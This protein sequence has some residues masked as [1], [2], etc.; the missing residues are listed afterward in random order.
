MLRTLVPIAFAILAG[1]GSSALIS[2][3]RGYFLEGRI[4][5]GD[6]NSVFV[7]SQRADS[8][9]A[10]PRSE[11]ADIDHPGNVAATIGGI[12]GGYGVANSVVA[13]PTCEQAVAYKEACYVGTLLP[14]AV[15]IPMFIYGLVTW[16]R[17]RSAAE[18][19]V[20]ERPFEPAHSAQPA[21][22]LLPTRPSQPETLPLRGPIQAVPPP[23][24]LSVPVEQPR[25]VVSPGAALPARQPGADL[26]AQPPGALGRCPAEQVADMRSHGV[27]EA[28]IAAACVQP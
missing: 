3:K 19:M 12:L 5:G 20:E 14:L 1:C 22:P 9:I 4:S 13:V 26:P 25:R 15:A 16:Q 21:Y 11:I 24:P 17:S 27:S 10:I 18:E 6:S 28:A 23:A 8:P 2:T 7:E